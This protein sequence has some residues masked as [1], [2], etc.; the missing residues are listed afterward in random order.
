MSAQSRLRKSTAIL[1]LLLCPCL[2]PESEASAA[3]R[4]VIGRSV[5]GRP[6]VSVRVGSK[7]P[8]MRMLVIGAVH[9]NERAGTRIA[10]LLIRL[11][12]PRG[13][14]LLVVPT[15]NPD[16]VA[17]RARGN[18]HGVDL[19]RNF[20]FD[21]RPL[22]GGEYSG[23]RPLSE[24]ES[25]AAHRL[26]LR[27]RPD[28]TI[29]FHQPFGLI[30]RPAGNPF[31]AHRFAQLIGLPLVDLPGR[32]PGSASRWQN[33]RLPR[34]TAFVAEL[35]ARVSDALVVRGVTAV[36]KLAS[37]LASPALSRSQPVGAGRPG[38]PANLREIA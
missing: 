8:T 23:P 21:W 11:G 34:A 7:E 12:A 26:I 9:G 20:P 17:A 33:H 14:E 29:W 36:H 4:S 19:N 2:L 16:G 37:E 28:V 32:Y 1:A 13:A 24:P 27:T 18:A 25:R 5:E 3:E 38:P 6:I 30:D 15:L 31:V 10:R 35:P 22:T